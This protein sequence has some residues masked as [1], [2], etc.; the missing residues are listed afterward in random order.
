MPFAQVED[1]DYVGVGTQPA[2]G[3]GF[4]LY[5][6]TRGV[7]KTLSLYQS[8]GNFPVQQRVLGQVDFLLAALSL[9]PLDLVAATGKGVVVLWSWG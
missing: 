3:L 1:G 4:P 6:F 8:E 9:E 2:H 5:A 7:I